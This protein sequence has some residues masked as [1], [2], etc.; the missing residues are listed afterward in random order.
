MLDIGIIS[1]IAGILGLSAT[2]LWHVF[3]ERR[4]KAKKEVVAG[5]TATIMNASQRIVSEGLA[6]AFTQRYYDDDVLSSAGLTRYV[7]NIAGAEVASSLAT[8]ADWVG[9][10]VPLRSANERCVLVPKPPDMVIPEVNDTASILAEIESR[11]VRIW[12]API[13]R[14]L[15]THIDG[16]ILDASFCIDE[17]FRYRFTNGALHDE[18]MRA[19]VDAEFSLDSI[20]KREKALLPLRRRYLPPNSSLKDFDRRICSSGVNVLTAFARPRP[21]EDFGII[22]QRR[23]PSVATRPW[24][25]SLL[26]GGHHQPT[27]EPESEVAISRTIMRELFEEV[28]GGEEV[29]KGASRLQVDWYE[30]VSGPMSWL[31]E[32]RDVFDLV[33]TG[34]GVSLLSGS[35]TFSAVLAVHDENFWK[36]YSHEMQMNWEASDDLYPVLSTQDPKLEEILR[37]R[38]WM[39]YSFH[40]V[41]EGMILLKEVAPER[42][43]LPEITRRWSST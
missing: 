31:H 3:L 12:N 10:R 13:F 42:V 6:T 24:V 19:I 23:G 25:L 39:D 7:V 36:R 40:S 27:L 22:L 37:R 34:L 30:H 5:R 20:F 33:M 35:V 15:N 17:F 9:R 4:N 28:F 38:D 2:E 8:R 26:P 11:G 43:R 21:Y 18:L 14:F 16:S 41:I 29:E 1:A 32:N